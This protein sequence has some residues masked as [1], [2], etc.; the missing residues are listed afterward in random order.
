MTT[1]AASAMVVGAVAAV[2]GVWAL[3]GPAERVSSGVSR[4]QI[5]PSSAVALT[6]TDGQRHLAI[7]PDG[8]RV[9]YVGNRGTQ[10]FVRALDALEPVALFTRLPRGP[11]IDTQ[12]SDPGP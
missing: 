12:E 6:I 5:V 11:R 8:S 1:I 2:I 10:L 7:T 9:I 4:L 3:T